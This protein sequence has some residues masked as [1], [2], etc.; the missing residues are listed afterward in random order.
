MQPLGEGSLEKE[1]FEDWWG[2]WSS[3]LSNLHPQI[4]EQWLY[5]HWCHSYMAFLD[6]APITWRVE[7]WL[8]DD[9]LSQVWL[10]FGGPMVP[11]HDYKAFN[12][13]H[14]FGP[15]STARAMNR[16]GTWDMPLLVLETP[17]GI[18]SETGDLPNIR[19][20]VAERSKRMRYLNAL[21][22]RGDGI[23]PHA[24]FILATPEAC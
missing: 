23:G 8:G 20:V 19:F 7:H 10:E 22:H 3:T 2:R 17:N 11:D 15:N 18:I 5:R 13:P 6:L 24:M 9:I 21:R 14:G 12:G 16:D 1:A 4:A